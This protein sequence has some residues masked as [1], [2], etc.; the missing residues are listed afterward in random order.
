MANELTRLYWKLDEFP[1]D[2]SEMNSV[3]IRVATTHRVG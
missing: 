2:V 3:A 1:M